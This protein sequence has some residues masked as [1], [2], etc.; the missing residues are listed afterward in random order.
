MMTG[1]RMAAGVQPD[2][3]AV[4]ASQAHE[5]SGKNTGRG[6]G[7]VRSAVHTTSPVEILAL[8]VIADSQTPADIQAPGVE[9]VVLGHQY[10]DDGHRCSD[11]GHLSTET[12]VRN[13][14]SGTSEAGTFTK[15]V[16]GNV[17]AGLIIL[18]DGIVAS[19]VIA[20]NLGILK[21]LRL[22]GKETGFAEAAKRTTSHGAQSAS[23]VGNANEIV[24]CNFC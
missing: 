9:G 20:P 13:K 16:T 2:D 22:N 7:S 18:P 23:V 14:V 1:S 15:K 24:P 17:S 6:T 19:N 4:I 8:S 11:E 10:K 5:S 3:H 12:I 21:G